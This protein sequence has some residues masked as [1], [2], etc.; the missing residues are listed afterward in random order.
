M[1]PICRLYTD[2]IKDSRT[3]SEVM[4]A[5]V[6]LKL[7]FYYSGRQRVIRAESRSLKRIIKLEFEL[8]ELRVSYTKTFYR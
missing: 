8:R 5:C 4:D 2:P 6:D 1:S 3:I 7:P